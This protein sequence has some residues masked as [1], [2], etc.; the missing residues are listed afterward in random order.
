MD[1][2]TAALTETQQAFAEEV[3]AFLDE[4]LT[5]EL[6]AGVHD[7]A[8]SFD[9]GFYLALGAKGWLM[10]RWPKE[11]G[12]ADLDD[13]CAKILETQLRERD[14][15]LG[16]R[17]TTHLA[18]ACRRGGGGPGAARRAEAPGGQGNGPPRPGLHR[19]G[20]RIRHRRGQDPGRPRRRRMGHQ[21]AEDLHLQ[22]PDR[23][24]CLPDHPDRP[25]AAQA[26]GPD[27]VPRAHQL[28][29]L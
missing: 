12:G 19:A 3:Q 25:D 26:Q 8:L 16:A 5:P 21:R 28:A 9:E 29:R 11:H 6:Y 23:S 27:H 24:V 4:Q 13:V 22:R 20:R 15:P 2:S 17:P 7:Q 14:A 1:F 10:P 18:L